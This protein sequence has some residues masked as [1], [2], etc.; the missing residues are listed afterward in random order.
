MIK[1]IVLLPLIL[2]FDYKPGLNQ[3]ELTVKEV[4]AHKISIRA[5][6]AQFKKQCDYEVS[7]KLF[8]VSCFSLLKSMKTLNPNYNFKSIEVQLD[9]AC[10]N[11]ILK[12]VNIN[13][14]QKIEPVLISGA[15][16]EKLILKQKEIIKYKL[17]I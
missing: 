11:N 12:V 10:A 16:C 3:W 4:S 14:I 9:Q 5:N 17:E 1:L 13:Q 6:L 7:K 15:N 8:P 2:A